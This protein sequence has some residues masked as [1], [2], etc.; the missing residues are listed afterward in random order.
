MD[1]AALEEYAAT[2]VG[3]EIS[4][5]A[6]RWRRWRVQ[7]LRWLADVVA[8]ALTAWLSSSPLTAYYFGR[9]TPGSLLASLPVAPLLFG[10]GIASCC[11]LIVGLVSPWAETVF[12]HA[13]GG[14]AQG[15]VWV[16]RAAAALPCCSVMIPQPTEWMVA[17]WY[18]ALLLLTWGLWRYTRE[19]D[20]GAAWMKKTREDE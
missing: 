14:L 6:K 18:A 19:A 8:V 2:N 20:A 13:A 9:L 12:N 1:D 16:A 3:G 17:C 11:G 7:T 15:M 4:E 10:V 5:T